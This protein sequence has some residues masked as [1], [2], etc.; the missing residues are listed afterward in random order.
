MLVQGLP[1]YK[2]KDAD[3]G[4]DKYEFGDRL[5][6]LTKNKVWMRGYL[7]AYDSDGR[8]I[9]CVPLTNGQ[10]TTVLGADANGGGVSFGTSK[11]SLVAENAKTVRAYVWNANTYAPLVTAVKNVEER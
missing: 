6:N 4:K 11:Q 3:T 7:A 9:N 10:G 1:I 5:Q 2:T 8:L